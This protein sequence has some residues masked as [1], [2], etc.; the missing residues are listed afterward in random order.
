MEPGTPNW[1]AGGC[2]HTNWS[3]EKPPSSDAH[4]LL[5]K[6]PAN[7]SFPSSELASESIRPVT[8][9]ERLNVMFDKVGLTS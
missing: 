8:N 2:G 3:H 4:T 9:C 5:D 1:S 7:T 6:E